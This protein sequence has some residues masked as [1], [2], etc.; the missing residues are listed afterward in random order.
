MFGRNKSFYYHPVN[1]LSAASCGEIL[2]IEGTMN[3]NMY[4]DILK[5]SMIPSLWKLARK[6]IFKH[7]NDPKH[8][9]K[10]TTALLKKLMVPDLNPTEH[11]WGIF[12]PKVEE[13]MVTSTSS[14]MSP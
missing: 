3:A 14:V 1:R 4:C 2:F 13:H 11:L 9:S 7:D 8:I 12:K 6:A 10:M 5:Q